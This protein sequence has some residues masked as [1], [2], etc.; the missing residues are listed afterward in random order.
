MQKTWNIRKIDAKKQQSFAKELGIS[1]ILA[2]ILLNR[3]IQTK[4][5]ARSYLYDDISK[6]FDPFLLKGMKKAVK[7]TQEAL[8]GKEKIFI[9]GDYDVDGLSSTALLYFV[10]KDLGADVAYY[11]PHRVEEGY[12]LNKQA[13]MNLKKQKAK[14]IIT[15]DC[16]I[17][18]FK[19]VKYLN[20]AGI[21]IIITDHHRIV[22]GKIPSAYAVI[23][24]M[25][26]GCDY[27]YKD[28]AGVGIAYKFAQALTHGVM[29]VNS[30]LDLVALG[31]ISDVAPLTGENRILV[32]Q[33]LQVLSNT[34]KTGLKALMEITGI[35]KE[36]FN[37]ARR[38]YT[39]T[40]H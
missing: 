30:H 4:E 36:N 39:W 26:K 13:C 5:Q 6:C 25:Q 1:L 15:V 22:E 38:I 11:I 2:Q 40:A 37:P 21:D 19:E 29:D 7:R 24:P 32:K 31:T 14:L 23:N 18:S 27:P 9:Y 8:A 12:S 33:G 34:N 16:G 20:S 35:K 28:L 3:G 10:L 17:S